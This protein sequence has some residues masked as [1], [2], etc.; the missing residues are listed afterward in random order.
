MFQF[1]VGRQPS[2]GERERLARY[3][4][5]QAT[6]FGK[7]KQAASDAAPLDPKAAPWVGLARVLL[8]LDE[9]ITRE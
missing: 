1:A 6:I 4:D 7:D 3:L 2:D 8:N 5:E 9:F